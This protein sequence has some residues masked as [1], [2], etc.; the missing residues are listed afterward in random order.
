MFRKRIYLE[1]Y[2][3]AMKIPVTKK[4]VTQ[5]NCQSNTQMPS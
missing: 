5:L 1:R 2:E 3:H 4:A